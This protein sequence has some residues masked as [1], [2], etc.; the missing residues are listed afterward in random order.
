MESLLLLIPLGLLSLVVAVYALF[1]ALK[2]GQFEDLDKEGWSVVF[3]DRE[4]HQ[5]DDKEKT[6]HD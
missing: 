2:S 5:S 6:N 1:K 3:D 4:A